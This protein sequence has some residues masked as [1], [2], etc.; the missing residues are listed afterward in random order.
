M[1]SR[2]KAPLSGVT[3][4]PQAR[5]ACARARDGGAKLKATIA[6]R[7]IIFGPDNAYLRDQLCAL[8]VLQV[9]DLSA[10]CRG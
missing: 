6:S 4:S 5:L 3:K 2:T 1:I 9:W 7:H 10:C 8:A